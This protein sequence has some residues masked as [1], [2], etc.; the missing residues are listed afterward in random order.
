MSDTA[1]CPVPHG[2]NTTSEKSKT[3]WWPKNLNL[4]ILHQ[5]DTKTNPLGADF[6]YLEELKTLDFAAL[7]KNVDE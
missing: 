2:A 6:D 5:H 7:K 3:D 4:E 1:K